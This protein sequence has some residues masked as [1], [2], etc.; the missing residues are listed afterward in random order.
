VRIVFSPARHLDLGPLESFFSNDG[1]GNTPYDAVDVSFHPPGGELNNYA[2]QPFSAQIQ[3]MNDWVNG[4]I[5]PVGYAPNHQDSSRSQLALARKYNIPIIY[6]E[7]SPSYHAG[8]GCTISSAVHTVA[9]Q[10]MS[11]HANELAMDLV[12][13]SNTL[14]ES[15]SICAN[16]AEGARTYKRLW[17]GDTG[18]QPQPPPPPAPPPPAPPPP[19]TASACSPATGTAAPDA[20]RLAVP[21]QHGGAVADHRLEPVQ[22]PGDRHRQLADHLGPGRTGALLRRRRRRFRRRAVQRHPHQPDGH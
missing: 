4:R 8:G 13:H 22:P 17:A 10:W 9:H 16:W 18:T 3:A 15:D 1:N 19:A 11:D 5:D 7:W 20:G 6:T 2:S 21:A 14:V 12:F